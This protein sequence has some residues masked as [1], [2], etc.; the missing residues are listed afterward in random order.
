MIIRQRDLVKL[1][2]FG[3]ITCGIYSIFFWYRYAEDMN[4]V[5]DGDGEHTTNFIAAILLSIIT[6]GIYQFYYFYKIGNRLAR[7][8]PRYGLQFQENGTTI[9]MWEI[10]ASFLCGLG[11]WISWHIMIKNMN[12]LAAA[13]NN[14]NSGGP[15]PPDPFSQFDQPGR[16][17]Q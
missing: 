3:L 7:N 4:I 5:C 13:Y 17:T 12:A 2:V 6:C 10:F 9:L 16:P 15:A 14:Y 1:I 8:A 11:V